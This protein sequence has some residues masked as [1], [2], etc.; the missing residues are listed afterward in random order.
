VGCDWLSGNVTLASTDT[1]ILGDAEGILLGLL[2]DR[3][4]RNVGN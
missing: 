3:L 2:D 4:S 1:G